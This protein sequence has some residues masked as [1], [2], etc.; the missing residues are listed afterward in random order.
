MSFRP[1]IKLTL[2]L[3]ALAVVFFRLGLWQWDR[4]AEKELLF[5]SFENAPVMTIRQALSGTEPFVQ[6]E[7]EGRY[8]PVRHTLLDNRIFKGRAGVHVLTPFALLDGSAILVNRGWLPLT[9][10]RR[11]L[12]EFN[13]NPAEQRISGIL[14]R[15]VTGGPRVGGADELVTDQWPQLMT[16][17]DLDS[18]SAATEKSLEPWILLLDAG[19]PDGFEDRNWQAAVMEPKVH[20]A[21]ALQWFSLAAA[22]MVIWIVLGFRRARRANGAEI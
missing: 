6:V 8:D 18:I 15:P 21:Y 3:L 1:S 22:A 4:K 16:Y 13:T 11:S 19:D 5:E 12:P 9:A 7:A 14:T 17:L 2:V 10:D 20:G